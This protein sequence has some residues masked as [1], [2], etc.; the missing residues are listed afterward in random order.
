[1]TVNGPEVTMGRDDD[2]FRTGRR[3]SDLT[4]AVRA[5][6]ENVGPL[7]GPAHYGLQNLVGL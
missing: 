6:T 4:L 1:M 2:K 5:L 7:A 3:R